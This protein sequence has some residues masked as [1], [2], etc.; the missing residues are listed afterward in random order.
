MMLLRTLLEEDEPDDPELGVLP[1]LPG[2]NAGSE[3][4]R[5]G[6]FGSA[7]NPRVFS[8]TWEM[9]PMMPLAKSSNT[10][11]GLAG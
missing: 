3:S 4:D 2:G 8:P 5:E 7:G 11:N 9:L 1:L 10:A 6:M